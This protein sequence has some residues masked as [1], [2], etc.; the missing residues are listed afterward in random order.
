[1]YQTVQYFFWSKTS[2]L[3]LSQLNILCTNLLK[4]HFTKNDG[5]LLLA[6]HTLRPLYAF[7][8]VLDCIKVNW[9][10]SQNVQYFIRSKNCVLNFTTE[11]GHGFPPP[12][13]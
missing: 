12:P 5:F 10:I 13:G 6:T 11:T 4:P 1:M 7:S 9:S 8:N 2:V 3:H